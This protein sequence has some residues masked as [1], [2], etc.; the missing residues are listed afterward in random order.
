MTKRKLQ[1]LTLKYFKDYYHDSSKKLRK[2]IKNN[3]NFIFKNKGVI[4]SF[5]K[6]FV[7]EHQK[8]V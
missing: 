4:D 2:A 6:R 8:W 5:V 7:K 3:V 1:K